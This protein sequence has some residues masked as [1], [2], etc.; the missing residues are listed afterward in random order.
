MTTPSISLLRLTNKKISRLI[1]LAAL[2]YTLAFIIYY[3]FFTLPELIPYSLC[4]DA[5]VV[6][7]N[8]AIPMRIADEMNRWGFD[9]NIVHRFS[10]IS[11]FLVNFL[12]V[13]IAILLIIRRGD[14]LVAILASLTLVAVELGAPNNNPARFFSFSL[15]IFFL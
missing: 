12:F 8:I 13:G 9:Y 5:N 1:Q 14:D 4:S 2:L 7:C 10:L 11:D 3:L 6:N 15:F